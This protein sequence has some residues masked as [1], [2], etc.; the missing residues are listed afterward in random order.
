MQ[1]DRQAASLDSLRSRALAML[2]VSA[3]VAGFFGSQLPSGHQSARVILAVVAALVFFAVT[4]GL[5]LVVL[6]PKRDAW[7]FAHFLGPWFAKI[8]AK[9]L[10]PIDVTFRLAQHFEGYRIEN[11]TKLERLY[12]CLSAICI[13]VG[14]QVV[15]WVVAVV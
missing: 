2:S 12:R 11:K 7:H 14:L 6:I 1:L 10:T 9:N 4:V 3:L 15:V 8:D 13:L 5:A